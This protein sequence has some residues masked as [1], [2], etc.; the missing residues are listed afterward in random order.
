M[1]TNRISVT[2][3][4]PVYPK[5]YIAELISRTCDVL[6]HLSQDQAVTALCELLGVEALDQLWDSEEWLSDYEYQPAISQAEMTELV[7]RISPF[8]QV[9]QSDPALWR[10]KAAWTVRN[11]INCVPVALDDLVDYLTEDTLQ[12]INCGFVLSLYG[13]E[14]DSLPEPRLYDQEILANLEQVNIEICGMLSMATMN[15]T[16]IDADEY[17]HTKRQ[18]YLTRAAEY[19]ILH[20]YGYPVAS[21]WISEFINPSA[22]CNCPDP[23]CGGRHFGF[24]DVS[25]SYKL[26]LSNIDYIKQ[27]ETKRDLI[28][29]DRNVEL[30]DIV[31]SNT[32]RL[33]Q[34]LDAL[35][36][37]DQ[38][39]QHP[40]QAAILID[41]AFSQKSHLADMDLVWLI[42]LSVVAESLYGD[43]LL[44]G[45]SNIDSE[46]L[47]ESSIKSIKMFQSITS[48][49]TERPARHYM[50]LFDAQ[51]F[52]VAGM[53]VD[54]AEL[55]VSLRNMFMT[56][57]YSPE[58]Y[59]HLAH[60]VSG[61]LAERS[62]LGEQTKG[63]FEGYLTNCAQML[64]RRANASESHLDAVFEA[65]PSTEI[66][67]ILSEFGHLNAMKHR[68]N[69][70]SSAEEEQYWDRRIMALT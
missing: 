56:S 24:V 54:D 55:G 46:I 44:E 32:V 30:D 4:H 22:F 59:R 33:I 9:D 16:T 20:R 70:A 27:N 64:A 29:F 35:M 25:A 39:R 36:L 11:I 28:P 6:P 68:K 43:D 51:N 19:Y 7:A 50:P 21:L 60:F 2:Q 48:T 62:G 23:D 3:L 65:T 49:M 66:I 34:A 37:A 26:V 38:Q 47:S 5:W 63:L 18:R 57:L 58:A 42:L 17:G 13:S 31:E 69:V 12:G 41:T 67:E 10:L 45:C 52:F 53:E 40:E 61:V 15:E 1:R 14:M 8:L